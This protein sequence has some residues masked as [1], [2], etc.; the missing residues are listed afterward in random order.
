MELVL[1]KNNEVVIKALSLY[2]CEPAEGAS[3]RKNLNFLLNFAQSL[4]S[5]DYHSTKGVFNF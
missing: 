4:K 5:S 1:T 3:L 2:F